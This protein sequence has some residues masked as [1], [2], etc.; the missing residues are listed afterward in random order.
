VAR[1]QDVAIDLFSG[2]TMAGVNA[3]GARNDLKEQ[4]L[5]RLSDAYEGQ[6]IDVYLTSFVTQ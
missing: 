4:L 5:E 6:V 1:A 3:E 2:Q